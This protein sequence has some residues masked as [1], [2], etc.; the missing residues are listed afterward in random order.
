MPTPPPEPVDLGARW[1][2]SRQLAVD[3]AG[4]GAML[5]GVLGFVASRPLAWLGLVAGAAVGALAGIVLAPRRLSVQVDDTGVR[6]G[7]LT[8]VERI[9]WEDVV[10]VGI[11]EGYHGRSGRSLG[12]AVCR[13][14]VLLPVRVPALT[15]T[16]SA[17]RFGGS[18]PADR[19]EPFRDLAL[20]T[21]RPW[22]TWAGVPVVDRDIDRWWDAQPA[23]DAGS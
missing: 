10:A 14:G 12:L 4:A 1:P 3:L 11:E 18:P 23:A 22:A 2:G 13:R 20:A 5:G 7:R 21:V 6:I 17:F 9:P 19:L 15:R 8:S 16:A